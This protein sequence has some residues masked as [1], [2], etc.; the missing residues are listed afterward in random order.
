MKGPRRSVKVSDADV[1]SEF[2][3]KKK[4][5]RKLGPESQTTVKREAKLTEIRK[6]WATIK[7]SDCW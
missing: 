2:L 3:G 5:M 1:R 7:K 4:T 6:Y